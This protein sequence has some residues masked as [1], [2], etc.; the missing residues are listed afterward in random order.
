MCRTGSLQ[1]SLFTD[2]QSFREQ[3]VSA[4]FYASLVGQCL[5]NALTVHVGTGT[6]M[7]G[8]PT[9]RDLATR[10]ESRQSQRPC[11]GLLAFLRPRQFEAGLKLCVPPCPFL[12]CF[13]NFIKLD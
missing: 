8:Y 10:P 6:N 4:L 7:S 5:I 3:V 13:V 2:Y 9:N 1:Q 11:S 12:S